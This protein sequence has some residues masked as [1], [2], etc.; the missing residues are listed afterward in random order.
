MQD[1]NNIDFFNDVKV[2]IPK[3]NNYIT[4]VDVKELSMNKII[5]LNDEFI[6]IHNLINEIDYSKSNIEP[7]FNSSKIGESS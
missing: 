7:L 3:K 1:F 5:G 6:N 4:D 2:Y